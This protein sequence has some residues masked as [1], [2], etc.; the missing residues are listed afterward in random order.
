MKIIIDLDNLS[1]D[2]FGPAPEHLVEDLANTETM[3]YIADEIYAVYLHLKGTAL[4]EE[5]DGTH[6]VH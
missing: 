4:F 3:N 5:E 6:I 1:I 2:V